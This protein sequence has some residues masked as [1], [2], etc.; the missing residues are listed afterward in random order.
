MSP[1]NILLLLLPAGR[2][3]YEEL[4]WRSLVCVAHK[5][6][7][8]IKDGLSNAGRLLSNLAKS[9]KIAGHFKHSTL[10]TEELS[11]QRKVLGKKDLKVVQDCP[12]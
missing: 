4:E 9:W 12:A 2:I 10:A 5:W 3:L 8:C 11:Q 6:R 1:R 7:N